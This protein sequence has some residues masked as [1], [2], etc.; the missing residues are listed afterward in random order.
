MTGTGAEIMPVTKIDGRL[1]GAG[2]PGP[3]TKRLIKGFRDFIAAFK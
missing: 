1:I 3:V 2:E